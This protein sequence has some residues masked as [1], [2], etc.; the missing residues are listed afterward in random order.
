MLPRSESQAESREAVRA[1]RA[2]ASPD[3]GHC[4]DVTPTGHSGGSMSPGLQ[5]IAKAL[6]VKM[7]RLLE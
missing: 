3:E 5:A 1:G 4:R 7:G 2:P 6:G